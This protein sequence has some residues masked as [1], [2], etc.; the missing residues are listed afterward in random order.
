MKWD[1]SGTWAWTSTAKES[2]TVTTGTDSLHALGWRGGSSRGLYVTGNG[3][4]DTTNWD[5]F[6]IR[7]EP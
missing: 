5:W 4:G 2:T 7:F 3:D 1:G 6:T